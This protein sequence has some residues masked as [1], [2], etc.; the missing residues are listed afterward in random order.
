MAVERQLR[1]DHQQAAFEATFGILHAAAYPHWATGED[2]V[3]WVRDRRAEVRESG[4]VLGLPD[5]LI[6]A[7]AFHVGGAVLTRN[8]RDF[9]LTPVR[10]ETY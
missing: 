7:A 8:V 4:Q 2:V 9:E 6:A 1:R 10:V 3:A 5:A